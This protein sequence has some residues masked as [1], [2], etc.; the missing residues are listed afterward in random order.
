MVKKKAPTEIIHFHDYDGVLFI[1]DPHAWSKA[2][3]KR[4]DEAIFPQVVLNKLEQS[5]DIAIKNNLYVVILGDLFHVDNENN[6]NLLTK[7]IRIFNKLRDPLVSVEGNHEKKELNV[8]DDVALGMLREAGVIHTMEH[9]CLY[10]CVH[11]KN[12]KKV[13]IGGT[14]YGM[15]IPNKVVLPKEEKDKDTPIIWTSHHDLDFGDTYP[16]VIP[17]PEIHGAFMLVNGHIHK[18]KKPVKV[19]KTK[20]HNPGNITR[21]STDCKDHVPAVWMWKHEQGDEL[22]P[23]V[24]NYEKHVFNLIGKQ[25][26]VVAPKQVVSADLET[27]VTSKFVEKMKERAAKNDFRQTSDGVFIKETIQALGDSM[28]T[29]KDFIEEI[30]ELAEEVIISENSEEK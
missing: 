30:L 24:L 1:G 13:Y 21:L 7:I 17:V 20:A 10:C 27:T 28:G 15:N 14:P 19:G 18:T 3:G 23:I 16:G 2:P 11:M 25:I 8:T 29:P 5:I 4:L 26:E 12:G 9:N 6:I 22:E